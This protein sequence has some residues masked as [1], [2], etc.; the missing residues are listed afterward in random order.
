MSTV[1]TFLQ[2]D[3]DRVAELFQKIFRHGSKPALAGLKQYFSELYL[4]NPAQDGECPSLVYEDAGV[5]RGFIGAIPSRMSY[6]GKHLRAV[7]GGNLMI[8][9]EAKNPFAAVNLLKTFFAGHQDVTLTDTSNEHGRKMWEG[10]GG[11]TLPL[12]TL[13]WLHVLS[14]SRFVL[15]L[16]GRHGITN[17]L[18]FGL[19]PLAPIADS[20]LRRLLP[21]GTKSR[22]ALYRTEKLTAKVLLEGIRS[23]KDQ[24]SFGPDHDEPALAWLLAMARRKKEYGPLE[25]TALYDQHGNLAGWYLYYPNAGKVGQV[26]QVCARRKDAAGVLHNLFEDARAKGTAALIGRADPSMMLELSVQHSMF[27]QRNVYVQVKSESPD[28]V[29]A[30]MN[31]DAF[32]T[33]LEGEWWTRLQGDKFE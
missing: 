24:Y 28:V 2:N 9:P 7:I 18:G 17:A 8:D 16:A 3:V 25:E 1:R 30:L 20:L 15:A 33:R 13:Q 6:K 12:F 31:G 19:K 14:P 26:L 10:L 27:F 23:M 11:V 22:E 5:V 21:D 29:Q 32:F 4:Q